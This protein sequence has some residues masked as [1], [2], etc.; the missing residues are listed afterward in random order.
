MERTNGKGCEGVSSP[1]WSL[2][3]SSRSPCPLQGPLVPLKGRGE[4][5]GLYGCPARFFLRTSCVVWQSPIVDN[6]VPLVEQRLRWPE[7][8]TASFV[9]LE[10][11]CSGSRPSMRSQVRRMW[12]L[13]VA[14]L[15]CWL[16]CSPWLS[17]ASLSVGVCLFLC[18]SLLLARASA[19]CGNF[20]LSASFGDALSPKPQAAP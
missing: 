5:E 16:T 7:L 15:F 8:L 1:I 3:L 6:G 10:T 17:T 14:S 4:M 12:S 20:V 19:T 9:R 13:H 18:A 11:Y 2:C